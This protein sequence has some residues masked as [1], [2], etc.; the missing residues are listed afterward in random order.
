[1][2][3]QDLGMRRKTMLNVIS[4]K[5]L[6]NNKLTNLRIIFVKPRKKSAGRLTPGKLF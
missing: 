6:S 3:H 5:E 2:G 1:M 4:P